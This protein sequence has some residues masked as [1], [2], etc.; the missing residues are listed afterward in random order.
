[1][2][3]A[4]FF[5]QVDPFLDDWTGKGEKRGHQKPHGTDKGNFFLS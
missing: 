2:S 4:P 3:L 1:M 5:N